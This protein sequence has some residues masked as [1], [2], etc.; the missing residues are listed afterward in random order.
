MT[1][2][3]KRSMSRRLQL[4]ENLKD[5]EEINKIKKPK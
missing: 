5:E 3:L 1:Y 4:M 2:R